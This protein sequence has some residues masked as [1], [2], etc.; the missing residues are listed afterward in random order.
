MATIQPKTKVEKLSVR[1]AAREVTKKP[2]PYAI[3]RAAFL[4]L[5]QDIKD[6]MADGWNVI[7]I[8]ETLYDEGKVSFGYEA[9]RKYVN[10]LILLP[11]SVVIAT[12][13]EEV[14]T[15]KE[16]EVETGLQSMKLLPKKTAAQPPQNGG[17]V[18]DPEPK[19]EDLF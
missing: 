13:T 15:Q 8:W 3:N 16:P 17:F 12:E 9:F 6:A 7:S 18:F 19:K 10:R 4:A 5:R 1:I 14:R 11:P 2:S